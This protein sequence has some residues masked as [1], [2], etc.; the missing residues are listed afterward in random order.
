MSSI[1]DKILDHSKKAKFHSE[2]DFDYSLDKK[3]IKKEDIICLNPLAHCKLSLRPLF[4]RKCVKLTFD[5]YSS[6]AV[7]SDWASVS[8]TEKNKLTVRPKVLYVGR[9]ELAHHYLMRD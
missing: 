3:L 6:F 7:Y 1:F 4:L 8:A 2:D 5:P 9:E